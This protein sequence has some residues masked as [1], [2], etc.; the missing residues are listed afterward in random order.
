MTE[1]RRI[2]F[3][4]EAI[5]EASAAFQWYR[6]RSPSAAEAFVSEIDRVIN[7]ISESPERYPRYVG[8]TY[9][10][11]LRHFPFSIVYRESSREI[12]VIA[13]AHGKRRPGYWKN[14]LI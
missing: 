9:R 2:Q 5:A 3:H 14:R 12:M 10:A 7:K 1:M 11:L 4:P 6:Q 8:N 13:I